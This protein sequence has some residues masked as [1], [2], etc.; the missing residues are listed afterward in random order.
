VQTHPSRQYPYICQG[1][2][3][4]GPHPCQA[5]P[6]R[7]SQHVA[8]VAA[9]ACFAATMAACTVQPPF[10]TSFTCRRCSI[11]LLPPKLGRLCC[12][13]QLCMLDVSALLLATIAAGADD[14]KQQHQRQQHAAEHRRPAAGAACWLCCSWLRRSRPARGRL[15][16][17]RLGGGLLRWHPVREAGRVRHAL[18]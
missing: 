1:M 5:Q 14:C 9:A 4:L 3:V 13:L 15:G 18:G 17:G 12:E 7:P 8:A 16:D 2:Q 11:R 6:K 10:R